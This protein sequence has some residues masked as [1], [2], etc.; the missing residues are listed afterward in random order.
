MVLLNFMYL[1]VFN[2]VFNAEIIL[3]QVFLYRCENQI[4]DYEVF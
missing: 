4:V 3:G 1:L 2:Y